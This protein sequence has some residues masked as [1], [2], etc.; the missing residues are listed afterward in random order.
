MQNLYILDVSPSDAN[1]ARSDYRSIESSYGHLCSLL[2]GSNFEVLGRILGAWDFL[3]L[4]IECLNPGLYCEINTFDYT[5]IVTILSIL[6]LYFPC[7][8]QHDRVL[9]QLCKR[10]S[11]A[12]V[13]A[14]MNKEV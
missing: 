2:Q 5:T 1:L 11:Q 3:N 9:R 8:R 6:P 7:D 13:S 12:C 14:G 4:I 10:D